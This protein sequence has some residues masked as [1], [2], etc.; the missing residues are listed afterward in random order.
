MINNSPRPISGGLSLPLLLFAVNSGSGNDT[1]QVL[2]SAFG[3]PLTISGQGGD[4]AF[5][6]TYG[7][8]LTDN[9]VVNGG[10]GFNTLTLNSPTANTPIDLKSGAVAFSPSI[11]VH[12]TTTY[13]GI[14]TLALNT[15]AYTVSGDL[16]GVNFRPAIV[17]PEMPANLT[18]SREARVQQARDYHERAQAL[19][20]KTRNLIVLEVEDLYPRW[21]NKSK[22]SAHLEKA[23]HEAQTFSEKIKESFNKEERGSYPN[24]DE[25]TN[26]GLIATRLQLE[27]KEAH[28]QSLLALAALER[29][30][31]GGFVVDFDAAPACEPESK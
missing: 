18:G 9:V 11:A 4:D 25:V 1:V 21:L 16:G 3:A 26:A 14:Q 30:T 10:D 31:A 12:T 6:I 8:S 20:V 5:T 17:G 23:Y 15:G 27:W 7:N 22:E 24:I 28:Y 19:V 2:A 29:A 13:S